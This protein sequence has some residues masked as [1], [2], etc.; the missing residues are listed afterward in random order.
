MPCRADF[1]PAESIIKRFG[2]LVANDAV[3]LKGAPGKIHTLLGEN[4]VGKSTLV[5]IIYGLLRPD[6]GRRGY[7]F[8]RI[9]RAAK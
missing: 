1:L 4:G 5:K 2:A 7:L 9:F 6:A 3:K 8:Y